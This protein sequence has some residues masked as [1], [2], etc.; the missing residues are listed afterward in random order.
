MKTLIIGSSGML[1]EVLKKVFIDESIEFIT[2]DRSKE[3]N[4]ITYKN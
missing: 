4:Q 1:G 2:H 3:R